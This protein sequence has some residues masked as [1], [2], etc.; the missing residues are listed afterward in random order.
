MH[1]LRTKLYTDYLQKKITPILWAFR[2]FAGGSFMALRVPV[3]SMD[4]SS[5]LILSIKHFT[6]FG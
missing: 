1:Y 2:T 3:V 4:F 5:F 6:S